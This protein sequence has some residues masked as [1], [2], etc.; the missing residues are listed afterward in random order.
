MTTSPL[1]RRSIR[2]PRSAA[3]D[4]WGQANRVYIKSLLSLPTPVDFLN[5]RI[6]IN[7]LCGEEEYD[8]KQTG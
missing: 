4:E 8:P 5:R 2:Y 3:S 1:L 7:S 6:E